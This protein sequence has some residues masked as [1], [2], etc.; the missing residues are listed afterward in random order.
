MKTWNTRNGYIIKHILSGRSNVFLLTGGTKT[1]LIDTSSKLMKNILEMKLIKEGIRHIDLLILTHSHYDHADN[2]TMIREKFNADVLIHKSEAQTLTT[3]LNIIP[4]GT[5]FLT[6]LLIK[7]LKRI[8]MPLMKLNACKPD[9]LVDENYDLQ[10]Y[11]YN[12]YIMHTPGHTQGSVCVIVDDEIVLAGDTLFGIFKG[13]VFPPFA[14]NV[15]QLMESWRKLLETPC[16]IFLPSHGSARN[17]EVLTR[18]Y[19]KRSR[20]S[21]KSNDTSISS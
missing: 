5:L 13:S 12:A 10:V 14:S 21:L 3:G 11:G 6:R 18:N 2:A 20:L 15:F 19:M 1:I 8:A 17:R 9:I 4:E 16:I 7:L